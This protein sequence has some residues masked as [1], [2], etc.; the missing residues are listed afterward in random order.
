MEMKKAKVILFMLLT[1][2]ALNA[3]AF[4]K[5]EA[6]AFCKS[7]ESGVKSQKLPIQGVDGSVL[8]KFDISCSSLIAKHFRQAPNNLINELM[9]STYRANSISYYCDIFQSSRKYGMTYSDI[10]YDMNM[11]YLITFTVSPK[12]CK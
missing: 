9:G 2:V 8:F 11:K 1:L 12:D 6:F 3:S 4:N 10:Y 7:Y 5:D